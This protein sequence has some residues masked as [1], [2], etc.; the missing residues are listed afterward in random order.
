MAGPN[1]PTNVTEGSSGQLA[2]TNA[3]H[4]ILNEF[5]TAIGT[6]RPVLPEAFPSVPPPGAEG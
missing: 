6:A 4:A 2:H 1:L 5:D 3:A